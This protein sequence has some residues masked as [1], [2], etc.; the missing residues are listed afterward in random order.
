[1]NPDLQRLQPYPF[2]KL[3][4]LLADLKAPVDRSPIALSIGEPRHPAPEFVMRV[5]AENLDKLSNYPL[6]RGS[7]ALRETIARWLQRRFHLQGVDAQD[8]KSV[9]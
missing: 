3:R 8:R 7:D 4:A 5:L 2:E 1:M 9:V 6:T